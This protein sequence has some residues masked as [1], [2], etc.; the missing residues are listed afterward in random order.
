[1]CVCVYVH[2]HVV[3][4]EYK[5]QGIRYYK[6]FKNGQVHFGIAFLETERKINFWKAL[7]PTLYCYHTHINVSL[8]VPKGSH[9]YYIISQIWRLMAV[10]SKETENARAEVS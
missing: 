7:K 2:V 4:E 8:V 10:G 3:T 6:D 5:R 9:I 1:M